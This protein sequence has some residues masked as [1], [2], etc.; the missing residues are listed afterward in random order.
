LPNERFV[1]LIQKAIPDSS[2]ILDLACGD[3]AYGSALS[4]KC[5][6]LI[7]LDISLR[8]LRRAKKMGYSSVVCAS[9]A[10][11]P[12]CDNVVD[13]VWAS[14][15][16]EHLQLAELVKA[17]REI[18][19]VINRM[20][21]ATMPNPLWYAVP[22]ARK[23]T[24]EHVLRYSSSS[25]N[26]I[27]KM[28]Q[29]MTFRVVGSHLP[30]L[31]KDFRISEPL[32]SKF[33]SVSTTLVVRGRKR[34][35]AS[36]DGYSDNAKSGCEDFFRVLLEEWGIRNINLAFYRAVELSTFPLKL[37]EKSNVVLD[38]GCGGGEV[39]KALTTVSRCHAYVVGLD[40]D[41]T[42]IK[43]ALQRGRVSDAVIADIRALPLRKR[44]LD[45]IISMSVLEHIVNL[46]KALKEIADTLRLR[47]QFVGTFPTNRF[48]ELYIIS[49]F[50]N[51]IPIFGRQLVSRYVTYERQVQRIVN[52]L[53]WHE[54]IRVLHD[55][56]LTVVDSRIYM[57][58]LDV[59]FLDFLGKLPYPLRLTPLLERVAKLV[60]RTHRYNDNRAN[61]TIVAKPKTKK[62]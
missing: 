9:V 33:P 43:K 56:G 58:Q 27:L 30:L 36:P 45:L 50:L 42:S 13:V 4:K 12:F 57:S 21:L 60:L 54:W 6:Q 47:G 61:I 8:R 24:P 3:G 18:E 32:L 5:L 34:D 53:D 28:S 37:M 15:I 23:K 20:V 14:E 29:G 22:F 44:S 39:I 41:A 51:L 11:L 62:M 55:S 59:L 2:R 46:Q 17:L 40:V 38:V 16:F 1:L 25:L 31:H 19:R 35:E 49:R 52:G 48:L 10:S 7:G 26:S